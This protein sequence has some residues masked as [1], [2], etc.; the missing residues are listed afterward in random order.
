MDEP[1]AKRKIVCVLY[2]DPAEGYP[3]NYARDRIPT[4]ARTHT[5]RE[6]PLADRMR[7]SNSRLGIETKILALAVLTG[8]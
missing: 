2:E 6:T 8:A 5:V 1:N 4:P 7:P 3:P